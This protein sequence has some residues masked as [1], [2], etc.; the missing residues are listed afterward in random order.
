[1]NGQPYTVVHDAPPAPLPGWLAGLLRP[2]PLPPQKP[3]A[4]PLAA[5]RRG[6]YLNAA[7]KGELERVRRS[8]P[9]KHNTALYHAAIALGQ[10]VA[11]GELGET[12]GH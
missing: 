5:D 4:V 9:D 3:V 10:L 2:A 6:G 1:M 11:S 8:G 12:R 7:L